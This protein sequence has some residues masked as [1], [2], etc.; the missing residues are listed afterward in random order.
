ME[1]DIGF[2]ECAVIAGD[3]SVNQPQLSEP[4]TEERLIFRQKVG[5]LV[6]TFSLPGVTKLTDCKFT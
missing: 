5:Q 2:A 1:F 3:T 4:G 6:S